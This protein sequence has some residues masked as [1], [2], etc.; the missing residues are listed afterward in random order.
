RGRQI[1]THH[2]HRLRR[3]VR[4]EL[5]IS[6]R[7]H[8]LALQ[9]IQHRRIIGPKRNR[10][11]QRQTRPLVGT[12]PTGPMGLSGEEPASAAEE[13]VKSPLRAE[14]FLRRQ[15]I[16]SSW[17]LAYRITPIYYV[18]SSSARFD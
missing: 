15:R 11:P 8:G 14:A 4:C 17:S 9:E 13:I 7:R 6:R 18:N 1:S 5:Q 16:N 2:R 3:Q 10:R 12:E